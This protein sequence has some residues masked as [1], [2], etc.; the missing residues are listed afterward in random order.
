MIAMM[1]RGA[2]VILFALLWAVP[3]AVTVWFLFKVHSIDQ[4]L[5]DINEKMD[6]LTQK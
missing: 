6:Q 1:I 4:S 5:K 2:G 3:I